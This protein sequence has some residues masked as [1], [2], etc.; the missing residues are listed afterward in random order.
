MV[1][2]EYYLIY[3]NSEIRLKSGES[4]IFSNFGINNAYFNNRG[5]KVNM[6]LGQGKINEVEIE[7]YEVHEVKFN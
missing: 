6:M 1:Y 7:N 3:G 2:D 4:K 5:D